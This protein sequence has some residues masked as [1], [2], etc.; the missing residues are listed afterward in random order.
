[1]PEWNL[2]AA[3]QGINKAEHQIGIQYL[4]GWGVEQDIV[5][6]A[7]WI[8]RAAANGHLVS[9]YNMALFYVDGN[10]VEPSKEK[11]LY[12]ARVAM[13]NGHPYAADLLKA[14]ENDAL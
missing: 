6:A 4:N 3:N 14:I 7:Q 2:K 12:W 5:K 10:G 11:A 1:M 8:E 9:Q 13:E